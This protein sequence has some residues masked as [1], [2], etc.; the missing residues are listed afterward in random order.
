MGGHTLRGSGSLR[1]TPGA[2]AQGGWRVLPIVAGVVTFDER[3]T[4]RELE[5]MDSAEIRVT[6]ARGG[7]PAFS[8]ATMMDPAGGPPYTIHLDCYGP[9]I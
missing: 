7:R 6:L 8:R 9:A 5:A 1:V 4:I 2:P 3:V